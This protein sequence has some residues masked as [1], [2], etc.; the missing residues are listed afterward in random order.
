MYTLS[1]NRH[2]TTYSSP[3]IAASVM[4]C[5]AREETSLQ[6]FIDILEKMADGEMFIGENFVVHC[7]GKEK[8]DESC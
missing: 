7:F 3:I 5:I 1:I 6:R 8:D 2:T 4:A